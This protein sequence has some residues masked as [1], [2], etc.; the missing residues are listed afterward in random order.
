VDVFSG[1][2]P[3]ETMPAD[4]GALIFHTQPN[5]LYRLIPRTP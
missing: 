3:V 4:G 2:K 1:G 5:G